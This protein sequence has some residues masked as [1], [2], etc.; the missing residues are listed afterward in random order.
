MSVKKAETI[1][2]RIIYVEY[3]RADKN[4]SWA[5]EQWSSLSA[6]AAGH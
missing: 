6:F 4:Q 3:K 1:L 5:L 2:S